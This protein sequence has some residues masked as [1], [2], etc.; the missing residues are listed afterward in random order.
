MI[1]FARPIY[2]FSSMKKNLN[3]FADIYDLHGCPRY[4]EFGANGINISPRFIERGLDVFLKVEMNGE[5]HGLDTISLNAE[6]PSGK[7]CPFIEYIIGMRDYH[8]PESPKT[9]YSILTKLLRRGTFED[10]NDLDFASVVFMGV[11]EDGKVN[12]KKVLYSADVF[13]A[14]EVFKEFLDEI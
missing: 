3:V 2:D 8:F 9:A 7:E 14:L 6:F 4:E 5:D 10:Q 12:G 11:N 1:D 13:F